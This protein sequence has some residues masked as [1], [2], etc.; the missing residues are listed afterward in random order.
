MP[1]VPA[2][3]SLP[4]PPR[5][6]PPRPG[7]PPACSH[8]ASRCRSPAELITTSTYRS[9]ARCQAAGSVPGEAAGH[10]GGRSP[11]AGEGAP[12]RP[13]STQ[14]TV[15]KEGSGW[16]WGWGDQRLAARGGRECAAGSKGGLPSRPHPL[17]LIKAENKEAAGEGSFDLTP[18]SQF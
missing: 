14:D 15:R 17:L 13:G 3:V 9:L 4:P 11:A 7:P 5:R 16:A 2:S 12:P 8:A 18:P 10:R 6:A 1:G